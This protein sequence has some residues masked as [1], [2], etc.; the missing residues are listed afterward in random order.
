MSNKEIPELFYYADN[1]MH[2]GNFSVVD[3]EALQMVHQMN[4]NEIEPRPHI[5]N[6]EDQLCPSDLRRNLFNL[7]RYVSD[8]DEDPELPSAV[9]NF[10]VDCVRSGYKTMD[11]IVQDTEL[12]NFGEND[13][14]SVFFKFIHPAL[15][16]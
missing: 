11:E 3:A 8:N 10:F 12:E 14:R 6:D 4:W 7:I 9:G 2:V 16:K 13:L 15:V 5:Q 1:L